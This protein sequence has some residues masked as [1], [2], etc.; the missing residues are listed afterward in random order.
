MEEFLHQRKG[1][2]VPERVQEWG[3]HY[4]EEIP[5]RRPWDD[6]SCNC[7]LAKA[8]ESHQW[9]LV[10]THLLEERIERLSQL[11]IRMRQGDC[12]HF[13]SQGHSRRRSQ[14]QHQRCTKTL[15]GGDCQRD[16]KGRQI[17][18]PSPD[19]TSPQK[20]VTFQDLELSSGED[21][22]IRQDAG[23][24]PDR[25]KAEECDLGT[26]QPKLEHSLGVW[27]VSVAL[28]RELWSHV[29]V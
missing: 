5:Q 3:P 27:F 11:A 15:A 1:A 7:E 28:C 23:Q 26:L 17:K 8:R 19:P 22:S 4:W 10:A 6:D 12:Q 9:V 2:A 20:H 29:G 18:S 13:H 25:R 16:S 14:G 24:S 21:P